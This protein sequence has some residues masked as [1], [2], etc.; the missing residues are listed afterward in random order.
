MACRYDL[1]LQ[2]DDRHR[3]YLVRPPIDVD[4]IARPMAVDMGAGM[5]LRGYD[6]NAVAPAPG[7]RIDLTLYWEAVEPP[8][9]DLTVFVHLADG[10]ENT[11]AQHDGVP[12]G[13]ACP[14]WIW[15]PGEIIVD[16]HSLDVEHMGAGAPFTLYAGLYDRRTGQ[17]TPSGRVMLTHL[18]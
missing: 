8:S 6:V 2:L 18:P 11:I 17:R 5:R 7:Q 14:T 10:R 13:G 9:A 12:R 16:Q 1:A 3:V 4:S 15:Q